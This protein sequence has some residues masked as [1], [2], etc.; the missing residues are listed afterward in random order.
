MRSAFDYGWKIGKRHKA[1]YHIINSLANCLKI[2]AN[3]EEVED[4]LSK[5]RDFSPSIF[6]EFEGLSASTHIKLERLLYLNIL[7]SHLLRCKCTCLL[8]TNKATKENDTFLCMNLD[9]GVVI[10]AL[11]RLFTLKI[12]MNNN[13]N[14][15]DYKYAFIG[16]PILLENPLINEKGLGLGQIATLSN[17]ERYSKDMDRNGVNVNTLINTTIKTCKNTDEV[18]DLWKKT[19]ISNRLFYD[20]INQTTEWCDKEG[21]ILII[22]VGPDM[23]EPVFGSSTDITHSKEGILWHARHHQWL[24][25]NKTGSI[26]PEDNSYSKLNAIRAQ[27]LLELNYGRITLDTCKKMLRD[28]G[29]QGKDALCRHPDSIRF[30][31]TSC[32]YIVQ[33]KKFTVFLTHRNPCKSKFRK[34]DFSKIFD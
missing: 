21:G 22:E 34:H 3:N 5:I 13:K 9:E 7:F 27:E 33:P 32:S 14:S 18:A 31:T 12:W 24:D 4:G 17:K 8:A 15:N 11:V 6:K 23:I 2:K 25:A 26:I 1:Q 29:K 20:E 19:K 16:I 10:T 30:V 28:H